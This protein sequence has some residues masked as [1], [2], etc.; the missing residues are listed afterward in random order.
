MNWEVEAKQKFSHACSTYSTPFA[1]YWQSENSFQGLQVTVSPGGL[2]CWS[3][4]A[5]CNAARKH[6][7]IQGKFHIRTWYW[8]TRRRQDL[9]N[10]LHI[11]FKWGKTFCLWSYHTSPLISETNIKPTVLNQEHTTTIPM[12][13]GGSWHHGKLK[14][15]PKTW[16]LKDSLCQEKSVM[17]NGDQ[18]WK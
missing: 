1:L 14:T 10:N 11:I 13:R 5:M 17:T 18:N 16:R 4:V 12:K 7:I 6:L 8:P 9:F 3:M 15:H 2:P